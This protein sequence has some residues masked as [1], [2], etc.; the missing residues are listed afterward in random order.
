M[1]IEKYF[2][3]DCEIAQRLI[4]ETAN[5]P[6][7][8]SGDN[9]FQNTKVFLFDEYAVLKMQNINVRNVATPDVDLKHLEKLSATLMSLRAKDVNV[10]PILAFQSDNGNGYIIQPRAKGAELY[11]RDSIND[12]AYVL[13]RVKLLADTP[14]KHFDKFIADAIEIIDAGII[15][16]FAGKDNFFY[17][18]EIGFQFVDLN[19]HDDFEYGISETKPKGRQNVLYGSFLPCYYDAL[20]KC[21]NSVVKILPEMTGGERVNLIAHN[22][23]IFSK[24]RAALRTNGIT[25]EAIY[26]M[27]SQEWF[28]PQKSELGLI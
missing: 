5:M 12:K 23:A 20:P 28:I 3:I 27:I 9:G 19:A 24:C 16:D 18:D 13:A 17:H 1:I 22:R 8:K 14:Q 15:V 10:I 6:H 21:R 25:E 4:N 26:D 7:E 2:G 11:D